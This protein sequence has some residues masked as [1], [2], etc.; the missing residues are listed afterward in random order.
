MGA[1]TAVQTAEHQ[2]MLSHDSQSDLE[3]QTAKTKIQAEVFKAPPDGDAREKQSHQ[4]LIQA[5]RAVD[6]RAGE[7]SQQ[8]LPALS[9]SGG[10]EKDH[11][12]PWNDSS[13]THMSYSQTKDAKV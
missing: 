10:V 13:K 9:L 8:F 11:A 2:R 1:D 7:Q 5:G 3:S 4:A 6:G 12:L